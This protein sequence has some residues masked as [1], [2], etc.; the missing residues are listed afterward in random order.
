MTQQNTDLKFDLYYNEND[1]LVL[2]CDPREGEP[3]N[4]SITLHKDANTFTLT[5]NT[6]DTVKGEIKTDEA[7]EAM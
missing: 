1:E 2:F 6:N 7:R 3:A 4:P 5:R